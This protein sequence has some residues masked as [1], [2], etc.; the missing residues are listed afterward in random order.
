MVGA[1]ELD[2]LAVLGPGPDMVPQDIPGGAA[3]SPKVAMPRGL[4]LVRYGC[5]TH[6]RTGCYALRLPL[7]HALVP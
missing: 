4:A 5:N 2:R 6:A 1:Q 3:V 7:A